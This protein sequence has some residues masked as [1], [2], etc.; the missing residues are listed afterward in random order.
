VTDQRKAC[1]ADALR[2]WR[3]GM[4]SHPNWKPSY[5][6]FGLTL[7]EAVDIEASGYST[8]GMPQHLRWNG[9]PLTDEQYAKLDAARPAAPRTP[10]SEGTN[11]NN[12]VT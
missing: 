12:E 3:D 9:V 1:Y 7:D 4:R 8:D 2:Q 11:N 6:A 10:Q 5:A